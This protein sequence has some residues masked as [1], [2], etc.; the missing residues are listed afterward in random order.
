MAQVM[1]PAS[2][3]DVAALD[4]GGTGMPYSSISVSTGGDA[5][6]GEVVPSV[7]MAEL[8]W[9][10]PLPGNTFPTN[11]SGPRQDTC[12]L[13]RSGAT[14]HW[15]LGEVIHPALRTTPGFLDGFRTSGDHRIQ[16]VGVEMG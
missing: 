11:R 5:G 8:K 3:S 13:K 10:K 16:V 7:V 1:T 14:L 2:R 9:I 4:G 6:S 15:T 12:N